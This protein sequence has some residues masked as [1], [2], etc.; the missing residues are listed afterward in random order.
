MDRAALISKI[1]EI[2][3]EILDDETLSIH[4]ATT[5]DDVLDWDSLNHVKLM[6]AL[7]AEFRVRFETSEITAPNNVGELADLIQSKLA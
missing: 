2:L 4:E 3:A 7:E 5:A 6:V 1:N